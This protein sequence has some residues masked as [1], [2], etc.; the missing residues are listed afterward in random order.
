MK[1]FI[2]VIGMHIVMD[3]QWTCVLHAEQFQ[4]ILGDHTGGQLSNKCEIF[5][6]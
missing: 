5:V 2:L 4:S 3:M 1:S 6:I